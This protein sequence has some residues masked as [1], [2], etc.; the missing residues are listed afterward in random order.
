METS[1]VIPGV[2]YRANI[3]AS[4]IDYILNSIIFCYACENI[5]IFDHKC[6]IFSLCTNINLRGPGYWKFN[7]SLLKNKKIKNEMNIFL[8]QFA[9]DK[10][11]PINSWD[12]V[13]RRI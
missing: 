2:I 4:R 10:E 6:L 7:S 1:K 11:N 5:R 8:K 13:K 3:L 12:I 9:F